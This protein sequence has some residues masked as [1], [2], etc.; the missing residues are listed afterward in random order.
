M[1]EI[2]NLCWMH[3]IFMEMC[4]EIDSEYKNDT[5]REFIKISAVLQC[6]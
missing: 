5:S 3:K 1:M 2:N 6:T 4:R